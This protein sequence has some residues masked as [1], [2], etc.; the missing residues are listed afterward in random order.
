MTGIHICG[1][2]PG[3]LTP[4]LWLGMSFAFDFGVCCVMSAC[5]GGEERP[6]CSLVYLFSTP[7]QS[8]C[9]HWTSCRG[10][11][12]ELSQRRWGLPVTGCMALDE[13]VSSPSL[14]PSHKGRG[15]NTYSD[16]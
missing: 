11:R 7:L 9:T 4:G 10:R 15:S 2:R 5:V 16:G 14:S 12:A 8:A 6:L 3:S 13:L 1:Q